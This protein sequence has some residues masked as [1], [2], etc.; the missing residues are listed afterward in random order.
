MSRFPTWWAHRLRT[1]KV[2]LSL[3]TETGVVIGRTGAGG[4]N[5][6]DVVYLASDGGQR[7]C[8]WVEEVLSPIA[9][10]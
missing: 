1:P 6:Y 5:S 9:E 4:S 2:K 10:Y 8:W 7:Q 3:S